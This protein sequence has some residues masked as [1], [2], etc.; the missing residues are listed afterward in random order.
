[1]KFIECIIGS[2]FLFSSIFIMMYDQ[3]N[4]IFTDF[5]KLLSKDQKKMYKGIKQER[6]NIYINGTILSILFTLLIIKCVNINQI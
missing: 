2:G 1:M 3:N 6:L 4:K 5:E